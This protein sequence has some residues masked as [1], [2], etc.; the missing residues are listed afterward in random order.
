MTTGIPWLWLACGLGVAAIALLRFAWSLPRRS[1]GWTSAAWV[2]L[3]VSVLSGWQAGGA[4]GVSVAALVTMAAACVPL[5]LACTDA[6]RRNGKTAERSPAMPPRE[7][8]RI[9]RR[10]ITFLLVMPGGLVAAMGLGFVVRG[11]GSASHWGEANANVAALYAV[12]IAWA[13]LAV[14]LLMQ[15]RRISQFVTLL[16]CVAVSAPFLLVNVGP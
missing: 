15:M 5:A 3:A 9:V 13:V 12:P 2:T 11:L 1:R 7:P 6:P 14:V 16:A 8:R 4:W 10:V